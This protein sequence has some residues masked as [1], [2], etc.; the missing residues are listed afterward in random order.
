MTNWSIPP[1]TN[2]REARYA[3]ALSSHGGDR[4]A[5]LPGGLFGRSAVQSC[6]E[7]S[8]ASVPGRNRSTAN[9]SHPTEGRIAIVTDAGRDA[10]D[11]AAPMTNGA[12]R[13]RRSRVVLTPRRRRQVGD[14]A[15]HHTND[16]DKKARSP[17]RA[18]RKPL[19]PLRAGMPGDSGGL[20]VTNS[21]AFYFCTRGRGCSGHPAFPAPSLEGRATPFG[22][23]ILCRTRAHCAAGSWTHI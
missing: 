5:D 2:N 23:T 4:S 1:F 12:Y 14:D 6:L 19:K 15:S 13:G 10:V 17:E 9:S 20:V 21:C 16:G 11:A 3:L 8:F 18:R 7:K 22:R